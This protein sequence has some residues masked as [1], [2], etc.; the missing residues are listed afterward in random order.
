MSTHKVIIPS[1]D[2]DLHGLPKTYQWRCICIATAG[3]LGVTVVCSIVA[4][5]S[6]ILALPLF[7][8]GM[9][10]LLIAEV[11]FS[12]VYVH[13]L[14]ILN[15]QPIKHE[16]D[17]Y[18]PERTF[19]KFIRQIKQ[20]EEVEQYLSLWFFGADFSVIKRQNVE[21]FVAYAFWY[22]QRWA[23]SHPQHCL[24][25]MA[26]CTPAQL[27]LGVTQSVTRA[28]VH[29]RVCANPPTQQQ[30]CTCQLDQASQSSAEHAC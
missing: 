21:E 30:F 22:R 16:P 27:L 4:A 1:E 12:I 11:I 25:W 20:F 7:L 6:S 23:S 24:Q 17:N 3:L 15:V 9:P 14:A 18:D 5:V 28:H 19:D 29:D 2:P 8:F 26:S 13:K 10:L